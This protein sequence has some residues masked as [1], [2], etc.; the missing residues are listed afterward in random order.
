ML[1]QI[2]TPAEL[3]SLSLKDKQALAGEIR[4]KITE[5]T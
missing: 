3:K 4:E 2:N 5:R 1:E